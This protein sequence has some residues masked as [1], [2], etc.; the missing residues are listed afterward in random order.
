MFDK[1]V[2][3]RWPTPSLGAVQLLAVQKALP[4]CL[5][6]LYWAGPMALAIIIMIPW[7]CVA[8]GSSKCACAAVLSAHIAR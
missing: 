8:V 3:T 2:R 5:R 7:E 4:F 6:E 1:L